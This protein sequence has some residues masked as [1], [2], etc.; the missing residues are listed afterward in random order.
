VFRP[1]FGQGVPVEIQ[2]L[3]LGE[4][5]KTRLANGATGFMDDLDLSAQVA[6]LSMPTLIIAGVED[7]INLCAALAPAPP[8]DPQLGAA[9]SSRRRA[10]YPGG[11][12]GCGGRGAESVHPHLD[13][14]KRA[15]HFPVCSRQT[16][17]SR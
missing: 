8:E 1:S 2:D 12:T 14:L 11:V 7:V 4:L 17:R 9:G 10:L 13:A 15:G 5:P 6:T 3:I 16:G